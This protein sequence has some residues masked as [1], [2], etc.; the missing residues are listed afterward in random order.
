MAERILVC[1]AWPYANGPLHVG[2]LAGAY[3]PS[4]IFARYQRLR[5]KQVLM[6][7]GSDCHGT[8][9]TLTAE[10]EGVRPQEVIR[11]SHESFLNTFQRLGIS[12]DLFT[13]TYTDNHYAATTDF[14]LKL[15]EQGFLRRERQTGSYSET[16][17]RFLPDRFVEGR[18]PHCGF[19][20]ARGDQCDNCGRLLDPA[21]LLAPHSTLDRKPISFQETEHFVLDLAKLEPPLM[22]WLRGEARDH[23][24]QNTLAFTENWIREG[25]HARAITRDLEW[26]VP[27]P[28]DDSR[29]KD[30]RIYVWFDAVIGYLS[31]TKEWAGKSDVWK[32]W[33]VP[34][35]TSDTVKSYYFVGKDNIPF[36]TI[37]WPAMLLGYGDRVLPY[38]VPAN[39]FLNLEGEKMSTSRKWALWSRD[40]ELRYEPDQIR[41]YLAANAPEGK[42]AN[43]SWADFVRRNNDE[44]VANWGNLVNRVLNIAH[45]NFNEVPAPGELSAADLEVLKASENAFDHIGKLIDGVRLRS[46]LQEAMALSQ[47]VNQYLALEEPWKTVKTQ[48]DRAG[49]VLYVALQAV[50]R[51]KILLAPFLPF[52]CQKLH[53]LLGYEDELSAQ[54]RIDKSTDPEGNPRGVLQGNYDTSNRWQASHLPPGQR[55]SSPVPLF[56]KLDDDVAQRELDQ[57]K[58]QLSVD[59]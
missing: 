47:R 2:H 41:Y 4:D 20:R 19:E 1:V 30:K 11:R 15:L 27:V 53:H 24:R 34:G 6:V 25:L 36:H 32:D 50:N 49:T 52:T 10:T 33:W 22:A 46:A 16:L 55:L 56:T 40:I 54:P 31:A 57:L 35:H 17:G 28:I 21:A 58:S 9:I 37:I 14:F 43:W 5:G 39:E 8:P 38:D 42:D 3:I 18:C 44:L 45:R 12:F 51:L 13:Q 29:Y 7:S 48:R 23:W 59:R 26:G